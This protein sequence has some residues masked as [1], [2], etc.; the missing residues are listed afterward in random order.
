MRQVKF[1]NFHFHYSD[2]KLL[3]LQQDPESDHCGSH[4]FI[5][6]CADSLSRVAVHDRRPTNLVVL[7]VRTVL[8]RFDDDVNGPLAASLLLF[9][10]GGTLAVALA[11]LLLCRGSD[12]PQALGGRH[13]C[14]RRQVVSLKLV[15]GAAVCADALICRDKGR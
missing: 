8:L 13:L 10:V 12:G 15:R 6:Q 9:A 5:V 3:K 1:A 4:L 14:I 11:H 7:S 2:K